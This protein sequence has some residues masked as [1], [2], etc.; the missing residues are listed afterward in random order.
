MPT[1]NAE[2][3]LESSSKL[4]DTSSAWTLEEWRI[5]PTLQMSV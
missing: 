3:G 4:A 1:F 5:G 2:A